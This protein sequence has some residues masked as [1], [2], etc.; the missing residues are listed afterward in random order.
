MTVR[1]HA[2]LTFCIT[3]V[4]YTTIKPCTTTTI[5][6]VTRPLRPYTTPTT[7]PYRYDRTLSLRPCMCNH[8]VYDRT[9]PRRQSLPPYTTTTTNTSN[10]T[11]T[12]VLHEYTTTHCIHDHCTSVHDVHHLYT[13]ARDH[14][15]REQPLLQYTTTLQ[16][17][18][19]CTT[20]QSCI[21]I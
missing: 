9:P 2:T 16:S 7:V 3:P 1:P 14:Y 6:P 11:T 12:T 8:Y 10:T 18:S 5:H 13:T 15:D 21:S 19:T 17:G 20:T 4:P